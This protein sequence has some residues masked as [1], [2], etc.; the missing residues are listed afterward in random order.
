MHSV[1]FM[2]CDVWAFLSNNIPFINVKTKWRKMV[3]TGIVQELKNMKY[4][5][6]KQNVRCCKATMM[7]MSGEM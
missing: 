5:D 2:V 4:D 6:D 1:E 7:I 3:I